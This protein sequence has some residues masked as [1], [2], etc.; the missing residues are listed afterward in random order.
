M[1]S[2]PCCESPFHKVDSEGGVVKDGLKVPCRCHRVACFV[3]FLVSAVF[4]CQASIRWRLLPYAIEGTSTSQMRELFVEGEVQHTITTGQYLGGFCFGTDTRSRN[5]AGLFILAL[6]PDTSKFTP[7]HSCWPLCAHR[8]MLFDDEPQHWPAVRK[9]WNTSTCKEKMA[10]ANSVVSVNLERPVRVAV[11][12]HQVS[13][14]RQWHAVLVPCGASPDE[15][16]LGPAI[17]YK[18]SGTYALS[19]WGPE[20]QQP[21]PCRQDL[22]DVLQKDLWQYVVT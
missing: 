11:R 14:A 16:Y 2:S 15:V 13:M 9:H 3:V 19:H 8:L 18:M 17:H 22:W 4:I 20:S 7:R 10:A 1:P 5:F 21:E 12:I 6:T